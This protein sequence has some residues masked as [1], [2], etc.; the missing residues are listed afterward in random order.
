LS[1]MC[2]RGPPTVTNYHSSSDS[3]TSRAAERSRRGRARTSRTPVRGFL[4][5]SREGA[6]ILGENELIS[7]ELA[8]RARGYGLAQPPGSRVHGHRSQHFFTM[9]CRR[10]SG[11]SRALPSILASL[12]P[13]ESIPGE[14]HSALLTGAS[15][16]AIGLSCSWS[17]PRE[18][19]PVLRGADRSQP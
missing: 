8:L 2:Y 19:Y 12:G 7:R 10:M 14:R 4:E 5:T 6:L 16:E 17:S 9:S 18:A 11:T 15:G 1:V 13:A 3:P